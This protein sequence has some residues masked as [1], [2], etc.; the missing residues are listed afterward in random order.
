[1]GEEGL[2]LRLSDIKLFGMLGL[3]GI[4]HSTPLRGEWKNGNQAP[5]YVPSPVEKKIISK[6]QDS[7]KLNYE[8][9]SKEK[10]SK[11]AELALYT[12]TWT[13]KYLDNGSSE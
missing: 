4:V 3:L 8:R 12:L 7:A 1:M 9:Y 13:S 6:I 10:D 11:R 5:E 2:D